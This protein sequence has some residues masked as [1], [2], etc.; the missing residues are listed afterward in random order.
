MLN[1]KKAKEYIKP[2]AEALKV[3]E[4][5]VQAL[6]DFYWKQVRKAMSSLQGPRIEVANFGSF[7]IKH[8]KLD[9]EKVRIQKILD[10]HDPEKMTYHRHEIRADM[11]VNLQRVHEIEGMVQK[12]EL[13]KK[14]IK[15][16]RNVQED[17]GNMG[18]S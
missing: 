11:E 16:K 15:Q 9:E 6:T 17:K 5:L 2:T 18:A 7:R 10:K 3:D 4:S 12:D 8:W 1:P 13:R 14:E